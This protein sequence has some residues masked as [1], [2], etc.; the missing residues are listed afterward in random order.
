MRRFA[1]LTAFLLT[2]LLIA[3]AASGQSGTADPTFGPGGLRPLPDVPFPTALAV[4]PDGALV[5]G[6]ASEDGPT[7]ARTF[8]D[9][10]ID[11]DFGTDGRAVLAGLDVSAYVIA[12]AVQPGG[13]LVA[14]GSVAMNEDASDVF[15]ARFTP[16]GQPDLTF[17]TG[18][19]RRLSVESYYPQPAVAVTPDGGFVVS[20]NHDVYARVARFKAQGEIDT[21]FGDAGM[22]D[23][24]VPDGLGG[25]LIPATSAVVVDAAGRI[26]VAGSVQDYFGSNG[27]SLLAIR[28]DTAGR[29][30]PSF[31]TEGVAVLP[32]PSGL[33]IGR[34][35]ALGPQGLLVAG[36][37][38]FREDDGLDSSGL[39]L[40]QITEVGALDAAF[41]AAG[42]V[43][44]RGPTGNAFAFGLGVTPD[45]R[46]V[47]GGALGSL[48]GPEDRPVVARFTNDGVLDATFGAGGLSQPATEGMGFIN[49]VAV[50]G[51]GRVVAAGISG[52][53]TAPTGF[54]T[55]LLGDAAT[56][57]ETDP[58]GAFSLV[59]A[60]ANPF[61]G[62]TSVRLTLAEASDARVTVVDVQ[63]R[64]VAT[65]AAGPLAA[66]EHRLRFAPDGLAAGA[67]VVRAE[68][69][70]QAVTC[71]LTHAR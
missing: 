71:R 12:V 35:A 10:T 49:A 27:Y 58:Q 22:I 4:Q 46:T 14:V 28:L 56:A 16:D 70:G 13:H 43:S 55:R 31:G 66:G 24:I 61:R 65:L 37:D 17:G 18:G 53:E 19:V 47:V 50:L 41:G 8:A 39:L 20:A 26:T 33:S 38:G 15:V 54:L 23:V 9:G 29:L 64:H 25:L 48:F 45:G 51:D 5:V 34:A 3:P 7:L 69:G 1:P 60:G 68:A 67:Y 52:S 30:D 40:A 11:T 36:Y 57:A 63:G 42:L 32:T 62:E 44:F 2:L 59:V 21:T 6:G